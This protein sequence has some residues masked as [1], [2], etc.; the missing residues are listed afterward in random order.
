MSKSYILHYTITITIRLEN[1]KFNISGSIRLF[2]F[3]F[4]ADKSVHVHLH[5]ET[6]DYIYIYIVLYLYL[7]KKVW[8]IENTHR[9]FHPPTISYP[10]ATISTIS[11]HLPYQLLRGHDINYQLP[12]TISATKRPRYQL[13]A[14]IYHIN[15]QLPRGKRP[16]SAITVF[17]EGHQSPQA[18]TCLT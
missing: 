10:E 9:K 12:S 3:K 2:S 8:G 4:W 16:Q 11:Y 5:L 13:L 18:G 6:T 1:S 7:K 14:T 17:S 15:N